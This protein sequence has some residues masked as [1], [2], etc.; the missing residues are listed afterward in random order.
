VL[1]LLDDA[2]TWLQARGIDQWHPGQWRRER[3]TEAAD[4]GEVFLARVDGSLA[5]TVSLQWRDE[6]FWPGAPDD[7]GYV[8]RLA[9]H[10]DWHARA[11]GRALLEWAERSITARGRVYVRLDCA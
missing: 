8:H 7:A 9:V 4:R 2:A 5:A 10:T 3:I 6:L 1:A 11:T